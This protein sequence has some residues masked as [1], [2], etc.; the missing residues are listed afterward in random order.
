M[1]FGDV[2][3]DL[4]APGGVKPRHRLIEHEHLRLHGHHARNRDAALLPAGKIER[5]RLEERF[6]DSGKLCAEADMLVHL[7]LVQSHVFRTERNVTVNRLF[8]ELVFRVLEHQTDTEPDGAQRLLGAVDVLFSEQHAP[9]GGLQKPVEMLDER[10]LAAAGMT[11]Q[12]RVLTGGDGEINIVESDLFKRSPG[13]VYAPE[14]LQTDIGHNEK[15][16]L[17]DLISLDTLQIIQQ[18]TLFLS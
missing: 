18:Q 2:C 14:R 16:L 7:P 6:I 15:P 3:K 9:R 11:E 13:A 4:A 17:M 10:A 8:K 12:R 1:V 5:G